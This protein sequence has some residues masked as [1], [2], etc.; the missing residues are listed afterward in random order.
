MLDLGIV[1]LSPVALQGFL[2]GALIEIAFKGLFLLLGLIL[3]EG[4]TSFP[5]ANNQAIM[6]I[7]QGF[8]L[9]GEFGLTSR[10]CESTIWIN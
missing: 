9:G 6:V 10:V 3:I 7:S 4:L 2:S 5:Q 1:A 8:F